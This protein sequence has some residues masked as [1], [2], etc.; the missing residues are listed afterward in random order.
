MSHIFKRVS[1]N[2]SFLLVLPHFCQHFSN[3]PLTIEAI[4]FCRPIGELQGVLPFLKIFH[5]SSSQFC[6]ILYVFVS[7]VI[8]NFGNRNVFTLVALP[9]IS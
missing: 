4:K 3:S 5:C 1:H 9:L 8:E 6:V 7:S 2:A